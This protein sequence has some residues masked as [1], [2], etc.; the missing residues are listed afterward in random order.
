MPVALGL[1]ADAQAATAAELVAI[2]WWLAWLLAAV[3][4]AALAG[5]AWGWRR[6]AREARRLRAIA[7]SLPFELWA[8]DKTGVMS[9]ATPPRGSTG[10][11]TRAPRPRRPAWTRRCARAGR[12]TTGG[13]WRASAWWRTSPAAAPA[14]R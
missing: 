3:G 9:S 2:P 14:R 10:A 11:I 1:A 8:S 13:R 7:D 12:R 6:A 4:V 5:L